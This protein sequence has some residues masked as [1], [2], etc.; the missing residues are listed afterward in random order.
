MVKIDKISY[1]FEEKKIRI[2]KKKKKK[3]KKNCMNG[4]VPSKEKFYN[5]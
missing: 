5:K 1:V 2:I 4:T 3:K